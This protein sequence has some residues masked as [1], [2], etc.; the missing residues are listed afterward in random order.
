[1]KRY[2]HIEKNIYMRDGQLFQ[3]K[4]H[5]YRYYSY[6]SCRVKFQG[7]YYIKDTLT[8]RY[9]IGSSVDIVVRV[10]DHRNKFNKPFNKRYKWHHLMYFTTLCH[11]DK[12]L[13]F[14]YLEYCD[15]KDMPE[16][17]R[18]YIRLCESHSKGLN[19]SLST[20]NKYIQSR[21]YKSTKQ[22]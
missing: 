1:M 9:Y 16:L 10:T 2:K 4:G 21:R 17:E 7:I 11:G 15:I 20:D 18:Y 12:Y 6:P 14:G 22:A 3:K 13:E 19:K 5:L 8:N